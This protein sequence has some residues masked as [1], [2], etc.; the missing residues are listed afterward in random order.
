VWALLV[1]LILPVL[2]IVIDI[3]LLLLPV[4]VTVMTVACGVFGGGGTVA[5]VTLANVVT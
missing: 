4:L 3:P 2:L 5:G 1:L